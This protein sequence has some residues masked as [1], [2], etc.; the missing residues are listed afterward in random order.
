MSVF[1]I[2]I[3][4]FG[5]NNPHKRWMDIQ[6]LYRDPLA[7][8]DIATHKFRGRKQKPTQAIH[9]RHVHRL[10]EL[11]MAGARMPLSRKREILGEEPPPRA[12]T[13]LEIHECLTKAFAGEDMRAQFPVCGFRVDL[14][15]PEH[16]IAVECDEHGHRDYCEAGERARE[17]AITSAL[18][19]R[20]V[21]YDPYAAGF[22]VFDLINRV[23]RLM[24]TPAEHP[25]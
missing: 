8:L 4:V 19:C 12:Y 20:W 3:T 13:E 2:L 17:E 10:V 14:Y 1:D 25:F 11:A 21:R 23:L 15:F 5:G 9:V 16:R 18:G 6:K 22:D 7:E 24:R